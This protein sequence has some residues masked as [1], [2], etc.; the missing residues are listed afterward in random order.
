MRMDS[1]VGQKLSNL[2]ISK[3]RKA[4]SLG[5]RAARPAPESGRDLA[6]AASGRRPLAHG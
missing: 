4:G 5:S 1:P 3:E 2:Y 6:E